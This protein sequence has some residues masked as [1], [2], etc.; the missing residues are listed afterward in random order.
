ME[1]ISAQAAAELRKMA[2]QLDAMDYFQVLG[3]AQSAVGGEIKKAFYRES[4]TYHPDRFFHMPDSQVKDDIGHLYKRI[5]ES[6]YV[7][8]DDQ[9]RKKYLADLAS[10]DRANKLRYTEASEAEVKA[11]AR[12]VVEEEFGTNPKSRPFFKS[13]LA[14]FDKQNWEGA[15]RNL[16]MGLMYEPGN[17]RFKEKLVEAQ[18]REED[19]RRKR[20]PNYMIK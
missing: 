2:T 17:T 18:K 11:E 10:A 7:L 19:E 5:T 6:Y 14:D 16:K 9:K 8:K 1:T 13:G 4:R 12:K 3:L 20:G 15:I